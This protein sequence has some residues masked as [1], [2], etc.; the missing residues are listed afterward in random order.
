MEIEMVIKIEVS[1]VNGMNSEGIM[2]FHR[3]LPV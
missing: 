1:V 3:N 2:A